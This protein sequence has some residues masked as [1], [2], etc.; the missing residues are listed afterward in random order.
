MQSSEGNGNDTD[1]DGHILE[2]LNLWD[3]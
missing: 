3:D 1:A 2:P